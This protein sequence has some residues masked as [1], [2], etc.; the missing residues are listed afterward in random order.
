MEHAFKIVYMGIGIFMFLAALEIL[1]Y[2]N[3][4]LEENNRK[5]CLNERNPE[6]IQSE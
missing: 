2:L 4:I 3:D 1:L 6:V 5:I